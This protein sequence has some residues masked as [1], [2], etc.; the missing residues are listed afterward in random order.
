MSKS[1]LIDYQKNYLYQCY[2]GSGDGL[3]WK[4]TNLYWTWR[5]NRMTEGEIMDR[6]YELTNKPAEY[7]M[8][9]YDNE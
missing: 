3:I 7:R 2:V 5:L 8:E 1:K 6:Y 9:D 4:L